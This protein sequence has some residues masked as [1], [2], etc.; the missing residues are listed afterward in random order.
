MPV[1]DYDLVIL[2]RDGVINRETFKSVL[3]VSE[4]EFLKGAP[5]AIS[6]LNQHMKVAVAT[7]QKCIARAQITHQDLEKI[8]HHMINELKKNGAEIDF[9]TYAIDDD[10]FPRLKPSADMLVQCMDH[11]GV[12]PAK[13]VF[14]GD[15][16]SDFQ[17]AQNSGCDF[18]LL[19][20]GF[21]KESEAHPHFTGTRV[22]DTLL[23]ATKSLLKML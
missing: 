11:F 21:G 19:R 5:E 12:T 2:D 10:H 15:K 4:F 18:I 14:I 3:S 22:Y 8:H 23:Q 13:S 17:A 20:E 7:N 16:V 9:L 6:L 1:L